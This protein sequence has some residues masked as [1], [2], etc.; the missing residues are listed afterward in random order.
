MSN[1]VNLRKFN[2]PIF[3]IIS[4]L[5]HLLQL[6]FLKVCINNKLFY[7]MQIYENKTNRLY[8]LSVK[9]NINH[10]SKLNLE[11]CLT[12]GIIVAFNFDNSSVVLFEKGNFI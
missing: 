4:K 7:R 9:N 8:I 1:F 3:P 6:N 10:F 11:F 12:T 2:V 5:A